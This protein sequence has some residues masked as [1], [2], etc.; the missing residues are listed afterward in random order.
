MERFATVQHNDSLMESPK[1]DRMFNSIMYS[2]RERQNSMIVPGS[3]S[4]KP[5]QSLRAV[6]ANAEHEK[7]IEEVRANHFKQVKNVVGPFL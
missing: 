6:K 3:M 5:K 4:N 2:E 7:L 1:P